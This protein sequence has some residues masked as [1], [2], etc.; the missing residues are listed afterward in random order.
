MLLFSR[1]S[2]FYVLSF[3]L[4]MSKPP[5]PR[6]WITARRQRVCVPYRQPLVRK[7]DELV[8]KFITVASKEGD[9]GA[10]YWMDLSLTPW[11]LRVSKW[12]CFHW[13]G[14]RAYRMR[15]ETDWRGR[16]Y[17]MTVRVMSGWGSRYFPAAQP[18]PSLQVGVQAQVVQVVHAGDI[19][20]GLLA[21]LCQLAPL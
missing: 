19:L 15:E 9:L 13:W 17:I 4:Y 10:V 20:R 8:Y 21:C 12:G 1:F 7:I 6:P 14:E 18:L 16:E 2:A 5:P 11:L 3:S